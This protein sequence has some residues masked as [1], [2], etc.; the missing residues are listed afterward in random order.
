MLRTDPRVDEWVA[1]ARAVSIEDAASYVG[2]KLKRNGTDLV[3]PCPAGCASSDGFVVTPRSNLFICRPSSE[4]GGPV[5]LVMHA[6]GCDFLSAC[7]TLTGE[8]RPKGAREE[9]A[10]QRQAR[11]RRTR[12]RAEAAQQR[13]RERDAEELSDHE[14][15]QRQIARLLMLMAPIEGTHAEAYL[16]AR[17]LIPGPWCERL[18][19]IPDAPYWV[20]GEVIAR[21]PLM[22]APFVK[23]DR[24]VGFHRTY[25]DPDKPAKFRPNDDDPSKKFYGKGSYGGLIPLGPIGE[26]LAVGE[27]I[28]TTVA[29]FQHPDLGGEMADVTIAAAGSLGRMSGACTGSFPHPTK[30]NPQTGKPT[31]CPNGIPDIDRPGM[32]LPPQVKTLILLG[33]GDSDPLSTRACLLAAA[34]R[35]RGDG[36]EV[37]ISMAPDG[38]DFASLG[39]AA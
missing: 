27:G 29:W 21:V 37:F 34:R 7:E 25:L 20:D 16:R 5:D 39:A 24:V 23:E 38:H 32:I 17:G 26:T 35:H 9:T 6:R 14:R 36:V 22:L 28:E 33:D 18:G 10:E 19:F 1:R 2:A 4:G 8:T 31:A 13:Q 15:E 11:E 3:G 12:E 30:V